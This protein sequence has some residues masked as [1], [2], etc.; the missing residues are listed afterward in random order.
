MQALLNLLIGLVEWA[1]GTRTDAA[2]STGSA[3]SQIKEL[4]SH[5]VDHLYRRVVNLRS[6]VD[7]PGNWPGPAG[8]LRTHTFTGLPRGELLR[9]DF[10]TPNGLGSTGYPATAGLVNSNITFMSAGQS[11]TIS[12]DTFTM[13][14][15]VIPTSDVYFPIAIFPAG[16]PFDGGD[17][18]LSSFVTSSFSPGRMLARLIYRAN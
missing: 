4:R 1:V 7:V 2:S 15:V 17:V 3:I 14:S 18:I 5:V 16:V 12:M 6:S 13:A 9:A 11:V 8:A 10:F